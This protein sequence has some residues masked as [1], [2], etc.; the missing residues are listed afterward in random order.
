V[1]LAII[2]GLVLGLLINIPV[3]PINVLVVN[4]SI[5]RGLKSSLAVG[6]GGALMDFVYFFV[7][8]SGIKIVH[9][10]QSF[11]Y[12]FQLIGSILILILGLKE[13]VVKSVLDLENLEAEKKSALV[14]LFFAGVLLYVSN[15]ALIITMTG[16]SVFV[17]GLS[18]FELT[19]V[20]TF[21]FSVSVTLGAF[22]WFFLLSSLVQKY[23]D[24]VINK[25]YPYF[26]KTS[27]LL[28][29]G[30]GGYFLLQVTKTI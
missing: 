20:N 8:L 10:S 16:I 26:V 28:L 30:F 5:K 17:K 7:I 6:A 25:L 13:I 14:G 12:Y 23:K 18:L 21:L 19:T 15:P 4:T 27:G 24:K 1:I 11:E 2:S 9:F 22:C 29:I 3:G